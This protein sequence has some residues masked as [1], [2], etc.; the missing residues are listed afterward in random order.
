MDA[1]FLPPALPSDLLQ[2]IISHC[3]YPTTLLVC[4]DRAEFLS[5]LTQDLHKEQPH[6]TSKPHDTAAQHA[7]A[8]PS[9]TN[10][11]Y[12]LLTPSLTQL[13]TTRH[14]QTH[15]LPTVSHLRALLA[16]Y[17][18]H[19][20]P[21]PPPVPPAAAPPPPPPTG[22]PLP[23]TSP[24]KPPPPSTT[25]PTEPS[26]PTKSKKLQLL[27]VYSLLTLHRHT[28]EWSVQGLGASLAALIEAAKRKG[29]G[30]LLVENPSSFSSS[31]MPSSS[32]PSSP[33]LPSPSLSV[34]VPSQGQGQTETERLP[35]LGMEALLAERV[36]VLRRA[37]AGDGG[38]GWAGKTVDVGRVLGRW[39][40]VRDGGW[41]GWD[42][43]GRGAG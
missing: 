13:A 3:A 14:I 12:P 32:S 1:L 33:S 30:V 9:D 4:S 10:R 34:A 36:P 21:P 35:S 22:P 6:T 7:T 16:V 29:L 39:F 43:E 42:A 5:A 20:P 18:A 41:E 26:P 28:S 17:S 24:T 23:S 38:A 27:I 8:D 40:R 19:T 25:S 37:P 11:K 15:F 31:S 2:F